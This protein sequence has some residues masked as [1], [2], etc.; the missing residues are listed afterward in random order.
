M[1][2]EQLKNEFIQL[3]REAVN[4][5]SAQEE[6]LQQESTGAIEKKTRDILLPVVSFACDILAPNW[7]IQESEKEI[8]SESYADVLDK[9]FPNSMGNFGIEFNAL[10]VTVAIFAPRIKTPRNIKPEEIQNVPEEIQNVEEE[11]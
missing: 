8:L 9:Y 7:Q 10:L 5:E 4:D 2:Q 1:L 11:A 3:E 6:S